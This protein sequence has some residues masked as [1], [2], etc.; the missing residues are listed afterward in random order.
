MPQAVVPEVLAAQARA[1]KN[2]MFAYW[3]VKD[4]TAIEIEQ[5]D[6]RR[7]GDAKANSESKE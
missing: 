4:K 2:S 3:T 7:I 6:Q 1:A 5:I